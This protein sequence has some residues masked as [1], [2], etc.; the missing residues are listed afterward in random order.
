M[1]AVARITT[2]TICWLQNSLTYR[3]E[4]TVQALGKQRQTVGALQ[5]LEVKCIIT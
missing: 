3:G 4:G 2:Q 1:Y 5:R